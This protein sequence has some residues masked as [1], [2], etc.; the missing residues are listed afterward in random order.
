M[1]WNRA[2][3]LRRKGRLKVIPDASSRIIPEDI[4]A[5]DKTLD[6]EMEKNCVLVTGNA[7]EIVGKYCQTRSI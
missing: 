1:M 6:K 3:E 4:I 2:D 5:L 7:R